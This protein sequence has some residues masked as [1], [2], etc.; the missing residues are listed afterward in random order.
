MGF[1][2]IQF[3]IFISLSYILFGLTNKKYK[4]QILGLISL[5]FILSFGIE[6]LI[7]F[8]LTILVDFIFAKLI[9][10]KISNNKCANALLTIC[11]LL[12]VVI[13]CWYKINSL[14]ST[15]NLIIPIGLSFYTFQSLGY[16]ISVYWGRIKP[17]NDFSQYL[18]FNAFFPQLAAGPI[19]RAQD[20][21]PQFKQFKDFEFNNLYKGLYLISLGLIKKLVVVDRVIFLYHAF[22]TDPQSFYGIEFILYSYLGFFLFYLDVSSYADMAKGIGYLFDI[23]IRDNFNRPY[24]AKDLTELWGRWHMSVTS[25]MKEF[26]YMPILMKSRNTY[27]SLISIYIFFGVWHATSWKYLYLGLY[28]AFVHSMYTLFDKYSN[29]LR[30]QW[31]K[32]V[33]QIIFFHVLIFGGLF[34]VD[35]DV[36]YS[37]EALVNIFDFREGLSLNRIFTHDLVLIYLGIIT[38]FI[39]EKYEVKILENSKVSITIFVFLTIFTIIF[40]ANESYLFIYLNM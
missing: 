17:I 29:G 40:R 15:A 24:L 21:I 27:L 37:L 25:W 39:L 20:I 16:I 23:K 9:Y 32:I 3:I 4:I 6:G 8:V 34:L 30:N 28:F 36:I 1:T 5:L 2:S 14:D 13:W 22:S 19:E 12:H 35:A 7:V 10:A 38:V 26:L 33:Q 18:S 11:I 31:P